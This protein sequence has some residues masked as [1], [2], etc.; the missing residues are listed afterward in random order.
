MGDGFCRSSSVWE[1]VSAC[2]S[3]PVWETVS[4][5]AHLY[6]RRFLPGARVPLVLLEALLLHDGP[7]VRRVAH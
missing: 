6:G 4:V 3:S 2:L 5:G 1:T 7:Q